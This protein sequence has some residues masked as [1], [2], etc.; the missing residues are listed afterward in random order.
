MASIGN[1]RIVLKGPTLLHTKTDVCP[2]CTNVDHTM[3]F[4]TASANLG[5][6]A[7]ATILFT[8]L[9]VPQKMIAGIKRL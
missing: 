8:A 7:F 6:T 9:L 4:A 5:G 2:V 1:V 3:L